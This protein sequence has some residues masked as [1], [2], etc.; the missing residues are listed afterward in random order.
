M[1]SKAVTGVDVVIVDVL[2]ATT[3]IAFA[4]SRGASVLTLADEKDALAQ[5]ATLGDRAILVGERMG[6]RLE[7]FHAN[8]SPTELAA[9]ALANKVVVLTTTN[10]TQAVAA[11]ATANRVFAGAITNAGALGRYLCPGGSLERDVAIVCAGR[12]TGALA[13][14]DLLGAGAITAAIAAATSPDANLWIADG[15]RV[16]LD[17]FDRER[18]DL[19]AAV[20]RSDAA[21]EILEHGAGADVALAGQLDSVATV[22]L[23]RDGRFVA[24]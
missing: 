15:A 11:C 12:S 1:S 2:R 10:G 9:L 23:L 8:N 21:E 16:A 5:G 17:L 18:A 14:E 22:P 13:L 19:A 3:T 20:A 24:A 4:V 6:Q 7:G